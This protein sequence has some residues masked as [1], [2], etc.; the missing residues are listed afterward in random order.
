[1][2]PKVAVV[3]CVH[4][5]PWLMMSTLITLALRSHRIGGLRKDDPIHRLLS[6]F[7]IEMIAGEH[8]IKDH[9]ESPRFVLHRTRK[10]A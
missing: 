4:H 2:P 5:K 7:R 3:F 10:A 6:G 1:M 9:L 8:T